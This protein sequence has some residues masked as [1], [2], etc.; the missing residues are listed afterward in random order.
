MVASTSRHFADGEAVRLIGF[1]MGGTSTDV[2]RYAGHFELADENQVAGVRIR[3]P[4]M[5]N[6][7]RRGRRRID[8]QLRRRRGFRVG[9]VQPELTPAPPAIAAA[10]R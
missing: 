4:M 10:G 9:A 1:D 6:P 5:R 2:S 8:L 7:H 3:A